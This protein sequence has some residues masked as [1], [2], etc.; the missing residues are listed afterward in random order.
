MRAEQHLTRITLRMQEV[1]KF[2]KGHCLSALGVFC[3]AVIMNETCMR[4]KLE[5]NSRSVSFS[6]EKVTAVV[7]I[8][9]VKKFLGSI[10]QEDEG[11]Q[12]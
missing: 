3:S 11:L 10:P 7:V 12:S 2:R 6:W 9:G 4:L 1:F 5:T 8:V